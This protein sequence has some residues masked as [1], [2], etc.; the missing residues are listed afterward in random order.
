M[1]ARFAGYQYTLQGQLSRVRVNLNPVL[2]LPDINKIYFCT[3][4]DCMLY[5]HILESNTKPEFYT[6]KFKDI[7]EFSLIFEQG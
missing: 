6:C 7:N 4:M 2:Y 5:I 1:S 3:L